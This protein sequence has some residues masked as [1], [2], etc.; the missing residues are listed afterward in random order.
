MLGVAPALDAVSSS[1]G[2][3]PA[4]FAEIVS[5][6]VASDSVPDS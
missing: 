6:S 3:V 1:V 4:V 5:V 2:A